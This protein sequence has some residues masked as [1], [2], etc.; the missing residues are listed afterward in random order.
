MTIVPENDYISK[1]RTIVVKDDVLINN[2]E[3]SMLF[4]PNE[5]TEE[6]CKSDPRLLIVTCVMVSLFFSFCVLYV[7]FFLFS[8]STIYIIFSLRRTLFSILTDSYII[9]FSLQGRKVL[10]YT[11]V[12][13]ECSM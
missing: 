13:I 8:F 4:S 7:C 6:K 1:N 5:K 11:N 10:Y 12:F 2:F 3:R 9:F